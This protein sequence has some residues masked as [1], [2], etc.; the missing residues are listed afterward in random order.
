MNRNPETLTT[1]G[2]AAL[3]PPVRRDYEGDPLKGHCLDAP[4]Y[5]PSGYVFPSKNGY[6]LVGIVPRNGLTK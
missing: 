6:A 1:T 5:L 3:S 4:D 2:L